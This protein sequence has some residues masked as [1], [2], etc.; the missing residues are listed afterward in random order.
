MS[1]RKQDREIEGKTKRN[2]KGERE[3]GGQKSD[4]RKQK[5]R[6]SE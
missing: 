3:S 6:D 5:K 4:E 2:R 1:V